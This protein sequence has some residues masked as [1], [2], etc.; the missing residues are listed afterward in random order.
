M[1]RDYLQ[2]AQV[3]LPGQRITPL[4]SAIFHGGNAVK[5]NRFQCRAAVKCTVS[6]GR[7]LT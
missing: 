3:D 1:S 4:E 7:D 6:N 2:I 5:V